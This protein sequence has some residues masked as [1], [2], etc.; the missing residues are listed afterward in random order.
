MPTEVVGGRFFC[1]ASGVRLSD[2]TAV[3]CEFSGCVARRGEGA[4]LNL[5]ERIDLERA[6]QMNCSI[7]EGVFRDVSLRGLKRLGDAPLFLWGCV[8]E[9]VVLSGR[10]S[11]VKINGSLLS[12]SKATTEENQRR[13]EAHDLFVKEF[14]AT[15]D[16]ALDIAQAEF[17]GGISFE[18]IPGDK[19]KLD[20]ERHVLVTRNALAASNWQALDFDGTALNIGLGRFERS[21]MFDSIV[22]AARSDRKWFKRDL[23]V[24]A[25]LRDAGI[26][27]LA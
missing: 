15:S 3:D 12:H 9:R 23:A 2:F 11:A 16:W 8:F 6:S 18:A 7:Y 10:I 4:P 19:I 26:A 22:L 21:S 25:R 1:K 5:F 27:S 14:Y 20:P 17:P 24:L 13:R